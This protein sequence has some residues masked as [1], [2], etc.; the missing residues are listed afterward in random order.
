MTQAQTQQRV[1]VVVVHGIADQKPGETVRQLARLLCH[2]GAGE[3][4]FVQGEVREVLVPVARLEAGSACAELATAREMPVNAQTRPGSPSGFFQQH[5]SL[6]Q[7]CGEQTQEQDLGCDLNDYLLSRLALSDGDAL[8][9]SSRVSLQHRDS[10]RAVDLFEMY[11]A[12][13][14][15]LGQGGLAAL[16]SLY[17]LFV[18]LSTLSADVVD[19]AALGQPRRAA[20]SWLQ[21]LHAWSAWL[22][23]GPALLVQLG[24]LLLFLVGAFAAVPVEQQQQVLVALFSIGTIVFL[25][26]ALFVQVRSARTWP[27]LL[28]GLGAVASAALAI[29]AQWDGSGH[30]YLYLGANVIVMAAVGF[31]LVQRYARAVHGV[32]RLGQALVAL[33]IAL[34]CL[35]AWRIFPYVTTLYEW[36]FAAA[37]G[38][39]EQLFALI[40]LVWTVFVVVQLAALVLGLWLG[41][42]AAPAVRCALYTARL[43]LVVATA[44]FAVLSLV[45]WSVLSYVAGHWLD[46][47]YQA[48]FFDAGPW[49]SGSAFLDQRVRSLGGFFT[50]LVVLSTLLGIAGFMVLAPAL[51]EEIKPTTNIDA[52]GPRPGAAEWAR[53]LGGWLSGASSE[54]GKALKFLIPA[55]AV[56]G[57]VL[58]L[59]FAAR[60]FAFVLGFDGVVVQTLNGWLDYFQGETLVSAGKWL[61][62]GALTVAALGSRF[63]NTFGRL[64]V[65]LDAVTDVSNYFDDPP[66]GQ[67]PRARIYSRYASL[68]A[69]LRA[70]GYQRIV[71]VAHSQGTVISADLLRYL[72]E[73]DRLRAVTGD[74][75]LSLLT[76][77]SPLRD[78]Y[79]ERFPLLYGWMGEAPTAFETARPSA[80]DIGVREWVNACRSGDYVGRFLWT[81]VTDS[82]NFKVATLDEQGHADAARAGDRTEFC[83]GAGGH[84]RYFSNDALVL[85][86]E[87]ERLMVE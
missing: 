52:L 39:G 8:Y 20:W 2:G 17:R 27:S 84:T 72:H 21:R 35:Q 76:V 82:A 36:L 28:L 16:G 12:D 69:Y 75:P 60:Q 57:S 58:Y 70:A 23:R 42:D 25:A 40:L 22:L 62:G 61:A 83:L 87:M 19:Q 7:T 55:G 4:R 54:V 32:R 1:A 38:V 43:G 49:P 74:L 11:W 50:P 26:L 34:L 24:M 79:A 86:R 71:I 81:P 56:A 66:D 77:G 67:S 46:I 85:A 15:R 48:Q 64:R 31:W 44:L 73:Q 10:Q 59:A 14:S 53:R 33:T 68:L 51:L 30:V 80:A 37:L 41:R 13:L 63:S 3:P 45:L 29:Y 9:Q 18:S 78:L 47:P 6:N 65:A 5:R